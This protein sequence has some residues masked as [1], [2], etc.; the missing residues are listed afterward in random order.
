MS[1]PCCD[2]VYGSG[3]AP[4]PPGADG[5]S[6]TA[7]QTADFEAAV[8]DL[9]PYDPTGGSFT[10]DFPPNPLDNQLCGFKNVTD[11]LIPVTFDG[12][13]HDVESPSSFLEVSSFLLAHNGITLIYKFNAELDAWLVL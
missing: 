5:L 9:V 8:G 11:S 2:T 6:W 3:G 10:L 12:N 13:G 7:V 1:V 4:V